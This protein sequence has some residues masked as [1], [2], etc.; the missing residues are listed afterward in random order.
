[1][2]AARPAP[3]ALDADFEEIGDQ[4]R[5]D[6]RTSDRRAPRMK[7]DPMFAATLVNQI[8]KAERAPLQGYATPTAHLRAGAVLNVR[9]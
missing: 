2:S 8:A 9:A 4:R 1:M 5:T 3:A 7:L 6:R